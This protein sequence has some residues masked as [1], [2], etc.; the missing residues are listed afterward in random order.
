MPESSS[1]VLQRWV[2]RLRSPAVSA[3]DLRSCR[4]EVEPLAWGPSE[5][6][7][8]GDLAELVVELATD[9][10]ER[11]WGAWLG[12]R[13]ARFR[14]DFRLAGRLNALARR[15]YR[16][17]KDDSGL[18]NCDLLSGAIAAEVGDLDHAARAY[19]A[20]EKRF[21]RG[22]D[23]RGIAACTY[24]R[25]L[26]HF[27]RSEFFEA[28]RA[29][30]SAKD[31]FES[32]SRE[33][34]G[35]ICTM[36]IGNA[37]DLMGRHQD[38]LENF[39]TAQAV[40]G[41]VGD[42][43]RSARC[44]LNAGNALA[45]AGK[46]PGARRMFAEAREVFQ[47]LGDDR[48]VAACLLNEAEL[49]PEGAAAL[50]GEAL[51]IF[52]RIEDKPGAGECE[53]ALSRLEQS[54]ERA[55]RAHRM[56][57]ELGDRL[58]IAAALQRK[59]AFAG[60]PAE[61]LEEALESV[62]A[63]VAANPDYS[64]R[65]LA[66]RRFADLVPLLVDRHLN[67]HDLDA[68]WQIG[69]R[70]SLRRVSSEPDRNEAVLQ[71]HLLEDAIVLVAAHG[72]VLTAERIEA[73]SEATPEVI[74]TCS[75]EIRRPNG[76]L[77]RLADLSARLLLPLWGVLK[78]ARQLRVL[79]GAHCNQIPFSALPIDGGRLIDSLAIVVSDQPRGDPLQGD[80]GLG[81][82]A[83]RSSFANGLID[84][85]STESEGRILVD[86]LPG[87]RH[88]HQGQATATRV[89]EGLAD[90]NLLHIATHA[91]DA[92]SN[93]AA[94]ALVLEPDA[95]YPSGLLYGREIA[96]TRATSRLVVLSACGTDRQPESLAQAFLTAGAKS[97]LA[98][99]WQAHD[100]A[101]LRWMDSF[102]RELAG[103]AS[104]PAAH[105][106]A[107]LEA[108]RGPFADPHYWALWKLLG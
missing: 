21:L 73:G 60:N 89:R 74:R 10:R 11:A 98:S 90:T 69:L 55:E 63:A 94:A 66:V 50:Y 62:E 75:D 7:I 101:T 93:P 88:L 14:A 59:A 65:F 52:S 53:L 64:F 104:A 22:G 13:A 30:E 27:R 70:A 80:W 96:A 45:A 24:N 16:A 36:N 31:A 4:A 54:P 28:L 23:S 12:A 25:G 78:Q 42:D 8:A 20:A 18:A 72:G 39:K 100:E 6:T 33:A 91:L 32:L 51:E 68:A 108:I 79:P 41:R 86:R 82:A 95:A 83:T 49:E 67:A 58:Q 107:C 97:V 102:Y 17:A 77:S 56:F 103:G 48:M 15:L 40:F 87:T 44:Q 71:I 57:L 85:P 35:A 47:R 46:K 99:G 5:S 9:D 84:L 26:I 76:E 38:A 1:E 81:L 61:L 34:D 92:P 2:S 43:N 105:R 3:G 19:R 29:Y 37:L 106:Q